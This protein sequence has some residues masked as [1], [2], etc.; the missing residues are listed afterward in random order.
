MKKIAFY[1]KGGIGKSTTA[2]NVSAALSLMGK[3]VC[4]IGCDPKN[5]STRLRLLLAAGKGNGVRVVAHGDGQGVLTL[6]QQLRDVKGKGGVAACVRSREQTVDVH[7]RPLVHRPEMQ[8]RPHARLFF[9]RQ[10]PPVPEHL[11]RPERL[12]HAGQR[13]F[14]REGDFACR[15]S[16][17]GTLSLCEE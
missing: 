10:R 1:G 11:P 12:P 7:P 16:G 17:C 6:P 5:D 14:R 2:S 4:Q 8:Q 3:K 13:R 15:L 9:E